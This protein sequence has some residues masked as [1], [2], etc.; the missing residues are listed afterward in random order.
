MKSNMFEKVAI[1]LV[2]TKLINNTAMETEEF[3]EKCVAMLND[4]FSREQIQKDCWKRCLFEYFH[5]A[6]IEAIVC[7]SMQIYAEIIKRSS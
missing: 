6:T 4:G 1:K 2:P 7:M 5:G 3:I